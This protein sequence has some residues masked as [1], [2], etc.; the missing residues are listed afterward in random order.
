MASAVASPFLFRKKSAQSTKQ[1]QQRNVGPNERERERERE[2]KKEKKRPRNT[3]VI[4]KPM[5]GAN[6]SLSVSLRDPVGDSRRHRFLHFHRRS[7]KKKKKE[8]DLPQKKEKR[9]KKKHRNIHRRIP[10]EIR[11]KCKKKNEALQ[12]KKNETR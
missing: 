11:W 8:D 10:I 12:K 7:E 2:N 1:Q 5:A 4:W 3:G 6:R 9:K